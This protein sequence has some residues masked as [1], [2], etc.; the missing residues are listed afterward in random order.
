MI[1]AFADQFQSLEQVLRMLRVDEQTI[2]FIYAA[3]CPEPG[4]KVPQEIL[5]GLKSLQG[6]IPSDFE[7]PVCDNDVI[8]DLM[9]WA[10][11]MMI[12]IYEAEDQSQICT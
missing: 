2:S 9:K 1:V 12:T 7:N 8:P 11:N 10:V 4:S 5:E 3:M 6:L